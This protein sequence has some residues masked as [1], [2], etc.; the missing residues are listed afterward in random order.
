M[1]RTVV[2]TRIE[3]GIAVAVLLAAM[4]AACSS[5]VTASGAGGNG[6]G[7]SGV[8]GGGGG[9]NG[10]GGGSMDGDVCPMGG[11]SGMSGFGGTPGVGGGPPPAFGTAW[12]CVGQYP[13][14]ANAESPDAAVASVTCVVGQSICFVAEHRPASLIRWSEP[15]CL[16][17]PGCCAAT[18]TSDCACAQP[19]ANCIGEKCIGR[20]GPVPGAVGSAC[21]VP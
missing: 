11:Q 2:W 8:G 19:G 13:P 9:G 10:V 12:E 1:R 20:N 7:G 18:P 15:R 4:G 16:P 5:T 3:R 14:L 21:L 17:L 6:E